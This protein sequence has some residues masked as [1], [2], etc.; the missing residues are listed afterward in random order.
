[1]KQGNVCWALCSLFSFFSSFL[2]L[3]LVFLFFCRCACFCFAVAAHALFFASSL[4]L[5]CCFVCFSF[6][7]VV[8]FFVSPQYAPPLCL[9]YFFVFLFLKMLLLSA[10]C[11]GTSMPVSLNPQSFVSMF[12]FLPLRGFSSR[13]I[14]LTLTK[15]PRAKGGYVDTPKRE[16]GAAAHPPRTP[17]SPRSLRSCCVC[18]A[19]SLSAV[20]LFLSALFLLFFFCMLRSLYLYCYYCCCCCCCGGGVVVFVVAVAVAA[21]AVVLLLLLLYSLVGVFIHLLEVEGDVGIVSSITADL[22]LARKETILG[23]ELLAH[24][25]LLVGG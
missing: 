9:W 8:S 6:V 20:S 4:S 21:A 7:F 14:T 10:Y 1:M 15:T 12:Y 11:Y 23:K 17:P 16:E 18:F 13:T 19:V 2:V 5:C 24:G 3:S 25:C 22:H